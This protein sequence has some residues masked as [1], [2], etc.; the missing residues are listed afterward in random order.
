MVTTAVF[1]EEEENTGTHYAGDSLG[2]RDRVGF[3]TL[4][5]SC[6]SDIYAPDKEETVF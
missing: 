4:P 3:F 5:C 2:S 1:Q 6:A